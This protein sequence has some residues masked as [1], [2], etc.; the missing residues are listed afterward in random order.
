MDAEHALLDS[1]RRAVEAMPDDVALR[2]HLATLLLEAGQRDEGIREVGAI[3]Q[4]D[5]G[6]PAALALITGAP[7]GPRRRRR[8]DSPPLPR[9][10]R[11]RPPPST[12]KPP[13]PS[14]R[15]YCRH[16][17]S[18]RTG[19]LR[20]RR[21]APATRLGRARSMPSTPGSGLLTWPD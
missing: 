4:R 11:R 3:L 12:G 2:L 17:S 13:S 15:T 16:A 7:A 20:S 18:D 8:R 5:P 10:A 1:L 6:N 14:W 19:H 21:T 9:R